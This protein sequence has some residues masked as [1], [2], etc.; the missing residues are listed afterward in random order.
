MKINQEEMKNI[1]FPDYRV[2]KMEYLPEQKILTIFVNGA[3]LETDT[4]KG[5]RLGRGV[6]FFKE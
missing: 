2:E 1:S 6:L 5:Y 3:W 4:D